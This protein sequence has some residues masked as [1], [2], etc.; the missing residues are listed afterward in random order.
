MLGLLGFVVGIISVILS[1]FK[2]ALLLSFI[3]AIASI[4]IAI[5]S[6]YDKDITDKQ[7]ETK[8]S[9]ALEVGTVIIAGAAIFS[10][11]VFTII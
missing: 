2:N 9:R 4:I 11:F 1:F 3:V 7:K 10:Y 5:L 8:D 6:A